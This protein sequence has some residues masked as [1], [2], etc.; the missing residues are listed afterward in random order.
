MPNYLV[1]IE[2]VLLNQRD[3]LLIMWSFVYK[4][5]KNL[6]HV[7]DFLEKYMVKKINS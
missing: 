5:Y 4:I 6:M 3:S 7:R 2:R 1:C